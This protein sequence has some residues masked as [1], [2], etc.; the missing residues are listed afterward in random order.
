M[1]FNDIFSV[2]IFIKGVTAGGISAFNTTIFYNSATLRIP[3]T[4]QGGINTNVQMLLA[5]APGSNVLD[6]SDIESIFDNDN[7][8]TA[9]ALDQS[10]AGTAE[11]GNGVLARVT[12]KAVGFGPSSLSLKVPIVSPVLTG[13]DGNAIG[14]S[15]SFD[16]FT[17]TVSGAQI[18]VGQDCP[19][20]SAPTASNKAV[21]G[22][23]DI[24]KT[25]TL[26]ASDPEGVC[27]L[28]F[29]ITSTVTNGALGLLSTP[30]CSAGSGSAIVTFNPD[31]NVCSPSA[32]S[33]Q[34]A[35]SDGVLT[36]TTATVTVSI[37]CANDPPTSS[38]ASAST[39]EETPV[40]IALSAEDIDNDCPLTFV[41]ATNPTKG[42]LGGFTSIVCTIDTPVPGTST[43]TADV[44]YTPNPNA[45]GSDSF[46]FKVTDPTGEPSSLEIANRSRRRHLRAM[47]RSRAVWRR[48]GPPSR[49]PGT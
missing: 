19:G 40:T 22:I 32:G 41:K 35:A 20:N 49:N 15:G 5:N 6:Q 3:S 27:P 24:P 29:E 34:Y 12:F 10:G 16:V 43:T 42:S 4:G 36:S 25:V 14:P 7:L 23:E 47:M 21:V 11:S 39:S 46:F 2:D 30:T 8:F 48:P 31:S 9:S 28:T 26:T 33:F 37:T 17:G 1:E 38:S 18:Y 45:F 13:D 44:L